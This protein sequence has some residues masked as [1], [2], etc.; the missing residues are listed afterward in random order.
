MIRSY[1]TRAKAQDDIRSGLQ[2]FSIYEKAAMATSTYYTEANGEA[3]GAAAYK[4][5]VA[6][7]QA[8]GA[9]YFP[10][11]FDPGNNAQTLSNIAAYFEGVEGGFDHASGGAPKISIG[12]YGAGVTLHTIKD[13]DG[14]AAYGLLAEATGWTGASTYSKLERRANSEH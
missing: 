4:D 13:T 7:G 1:L 12:V 14:L 9:I 6:A 11:D 5:T 2:I 3:D 10:V 8:A